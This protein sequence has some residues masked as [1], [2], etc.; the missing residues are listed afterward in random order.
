MR[1][2][3]AAV[4]ILAAAAPARALG[5]AGEAAR[6][7]DPTA[8]PAL[9]EQKPAAEE[10]WYGAPAVMSEGAALGLV[11]VGGVMTNQPGQSTPAL[12]KDLIALGV[13]AW[14][15]GPPVNHAANRHAGRALESFGLRLAAFVVPLAAGFGLS[16][17]MNHGGGL[18]CTGDPPPQDCSGL[19]A[20]VAVLGVLG[21]TVSVMVVDDWL[22]AREEAAPRANGLAL[23]PR[24]CV[25]RDEAVLS[26]AARF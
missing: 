8:V 26:L 20:A 17:A 22:L 9:A 24:L 6:P 11:I 14:F 25:D 12:G 4:A 2:A 21:G 23:V 15:L 13:T 19:P 5:T 3:A 16:A 10:R 7:T 18:L 1:R